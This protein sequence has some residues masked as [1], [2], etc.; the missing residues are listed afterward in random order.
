MAARGECESSDRL[1]S[2]RNRR[3]WRRT[4]RLAAPLAS[5]R[6]RAAPGRRPDAAPRHRRSPLRDRLRDC[7]RRA[8]SSRAWAVRSRRH[9]RAGGVFSRPGA[10]PQAPAP[11]RP[12]ALPEPSL[13]R[14][15]Q[16]RG[17]SGLGSASGCRL[18][19]RRR[20]A[21]TLRPSIAQS[22]LP[23]C[24][25]ER[26]GG[27]HD[28]DGADRNGQREALATAWPTAHIDSAGR[29]CHTGW[30]TT[31]CE[32]RTA[33]SETGQPISRVHNVCGWDS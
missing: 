21:S 6:P 31:T 1:P 20:S 32:G 16:K 27:Q 33:R 25:R 2:C 22:R 30:S 28:G 13:P 26:A 19:D 11:A 24:G 17:R 15:A 9:G 23:T 29:H 12:Q 8:S 5:A 7:R 4:R 3:R 18:P 10:R 14:L